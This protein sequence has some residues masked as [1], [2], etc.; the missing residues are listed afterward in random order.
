LF[1]VP[2]RTL[3]LFTKLVNDKLRRMGQS[4]L[5]MAAAAALLLGPPAD[6]EQLLTFPVAQKPELFQVQKTLVEAW[7]LLSEAYVDPSYNHV[8]WQQELSKALNTVAASESPK[9]ASN[10]IAS[11]VGKLGDPFT[12]WVPPE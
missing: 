5:G 12:R 2:N 10:E 3:D 6:A 1:A 9:E 4:A 8:D 11:M 7:T